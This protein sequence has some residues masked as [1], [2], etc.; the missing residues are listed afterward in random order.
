M[1]TKKEGKI[2]GMIPEKKTEI[3]KQDNEQLTK[4]KQDALMVLLCQSEDC[5]KMMVQVRTKIAILLKG[6]P[7]ERLRDIAKIK[8]F[9]DINDRMQKLD[10]ILQS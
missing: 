8:R 7:T 9:K 2:V 3:K 5:L 6:I 4:N 1:K 10:Q